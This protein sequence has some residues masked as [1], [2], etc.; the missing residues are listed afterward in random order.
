MGN[1]IILGQTGIDVSGKSIER[2]GPG[3]PR[4]QKRDKIE[5]WDFHF[6]QQIFL[7]L[8][9]YG[10][11]IFP[12]VIVCFMQFGFDRKGIV[13]VL[14]SNELFYASCVVCCLYLIDFISFKQKKYRKG[15]YI[16]YN[17]FLSMYLGIL[18]LG[19]VINVMYVVNT[20]NNTSDMISAFRNIFD[21]KLG[22]VIC[23]ALFPFCI[24]FLQR[25]LY[26][27]SVR[28]KNG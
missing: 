9:N 7:G 17:I 16:Q 22:I 11:A 12:V 6:I 28:L 19:L 8:A 13:T 27:L 24:L 26:Y 18:G 2:N 4:K 3:K 10:I 14:S 25:A 5:F 1:R 21:N 20:G 15:Y 23:W